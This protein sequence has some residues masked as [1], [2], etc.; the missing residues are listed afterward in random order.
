MPM[1]YCRHCGQKIDATAPACPHCGAPQIN[2]PVA[3]AAAQSSSGLQY[4]LPIGR[5]GWAIAAGYLG[6]F[7]VLLLPAPLAL[8]CG[9]MGLY[10]IARHPKKTGKPRAIFG[11]IM[12][13]IGCG[14]I[15]KI[16]MDAGG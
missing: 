4:V 10:D 5:S 12:G 16:L 8:L 6:L 7:S 15:A 3:A 2:P 1:A 11:I 9:G 13:L 14:L